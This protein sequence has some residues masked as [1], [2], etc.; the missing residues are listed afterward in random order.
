MDHRLDG[1]PR[2]A[3][4]VGH[5]GRG[6]RGGHVATTAPEVGAPVG[7]VAPCPDR[8]CH[9]RRYPPAAVL[10]SG[11][12]TSDVAGIEVDLAEIDENLIR[13]KLT[14]LERAEQ[15]ERRKRIYVQKGGKIFPTPGGEQEIGFAKDTAEKI[16][17]AKRTINEAIAIADGIPDQPR[18]LVLIWPDIKNKL[19][20]FWRRRSQNLRHF[21]GPGQSGPNLVRSFRYIQHRS[22]SNC[23]LRRLSPWKQL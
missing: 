2:L 15:L 11:S 3:R 7:A 22:Y 20:R 21:A 16:N 5:R 1:L 23:D 19:V 10:R 12:G 9:R 14:A 8:H 18:S 17:L 6:R 4:W 13:L